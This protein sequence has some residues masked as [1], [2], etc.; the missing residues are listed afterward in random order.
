MLFANPRAREITGLSESEL[1]D[2]E[3]YNLI[4]PGEHERA[5]RLLRGF[6]EGIYPRG[7]DIALNTKD[8][9]LITISVSFSS[10]LHEDNA[11]VHV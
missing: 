8:G 9:Q 11:S 7:V 10:V 2:L 6:R 4:G 1:V 5:Q 3:F